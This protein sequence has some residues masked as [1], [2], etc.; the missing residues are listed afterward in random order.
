MSRVLPLVVSVLL[1]ACGGS[2]ESDPIQPLDL[3]LQAEAWENRM[4]TAL[5]PGQ[6]P[7]CTSLIVAFSIRAEGA[8]L[9]AGIAARAVSLDKPGKATWQAAVSPTETGVTSEN[10]L[11]GVARGCA[12]S[13]F[14]EGDELLVGVSV[15]AAGRQEI[16]QAR[17]KLYAAY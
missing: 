11:A 4:P 5:L 9:P 15:A 8:G 10:V 17:V 1:V 12:T 13:D 16:V 14:A 6:V 3:R 7:S 2:Q